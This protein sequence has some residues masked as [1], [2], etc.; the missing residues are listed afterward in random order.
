MFIYNHEALF[1]MNYAQII[2]A[3]PAISPFQQELVQYYY[4][5]DDKDIK[6]KN[7]NFDR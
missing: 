5:P 4:V 3:N 1:F 6:S 2:Y 7:K